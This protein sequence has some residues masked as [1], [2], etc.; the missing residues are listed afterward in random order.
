MLLGRIKH[1]GACLHAGIVHNDVEAPETGN[2]CVHELLQIGC[3]THIGLDMDGFVAEGK[4]LLLES[5]CGFGVNNIVDH[6]VCTLF[7]EFQNDR[8]TDA[9]VPSGD[10]SCF[11]LECHKSKNTLPFEACRQSKIGHYDSA[12]SK[13]G[14]SS[15]VR[16]GGS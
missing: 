15:T 9:A 3:F 10:D 5:H 6:N 11:S 8:E 7:G 16:A 14:H 4:H 12:Q 2:G 13:R 1:G